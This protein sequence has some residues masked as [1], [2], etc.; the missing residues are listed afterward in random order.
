MGNL[1]QEQG[2]G[3]LRKDDY[4]DK[5]C[6]DRYTW[7]VRPNVV[8]FLEAHISYNSHQHQ[9]RGSC[10]GSLGVGSNAQS[11]VEIQ[12]QHPTAVL[13]GGRDFK[14]VEEAISLAP[15]RRIMVDHSREKDCGFLRIDFNS[16]GE[17]SYVEAYSDLVSVKS[18][19]L[20]ICCREDT[21]GIHKYMMIWKL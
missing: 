16:H 2:G 4:S 8:Q 5:S 3:N 1:A 9:N 19:D 14:Q 20:L 21:M 13:G 11:L 12:H 18:Y 15:L 10:S 17:L 6:S 7:L